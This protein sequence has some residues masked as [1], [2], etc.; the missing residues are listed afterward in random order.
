M[1]YHTISHNPVA[2]KQLMVDLFLESHDAGYRTESSWI[3]M[4]LMTRYTAS[5]PPSERL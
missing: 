3:L 2:L 5:L 4:R 1:R